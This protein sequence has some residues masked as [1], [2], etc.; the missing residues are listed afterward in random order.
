VAFSLFLKDA[1]EECIFYAEPGALPTRAIWMTL[2]PNLVFRCRWTFL[3]FFSSFFERRKRR[4]L[5]L[6][7]CCFR[8]PETFFPFLRMM[9][10]LLPPD[11][12]SFPFLQPTPPLT[13]ASFSSSSLFPENV[14]ANRVTHP[15]PTEKLF[16]KAFSLKGPSIAPAGERLPHDRMASPLRRARSSR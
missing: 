9:V 12:F 7:S 8:V 1:H 13:K 11:F 5:R 15:L 2:R 4:F 10:G 16:L 3:P 6:P 14:R